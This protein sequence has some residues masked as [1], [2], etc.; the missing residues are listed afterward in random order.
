MRWQRLGGALMFVIGFIAETSPAAAQTFNS[1][2]CADHTQFILAF[3]PSDKRAYLQIDGHAVT[4]KR[5][6]SLRGWR[7]AGGGVSFV[8]S[9]T[10]IHLKH[11]RR[12]VTACELS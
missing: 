11:A 9:P 6:A 2:R 10:G 4:L 3:Y 12:P 8:M 1:Y 5:R 7:Y